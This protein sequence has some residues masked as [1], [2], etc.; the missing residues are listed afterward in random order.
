MKTHLVSY[1]TARF[2][3]S[4]KKLGRSALRHGIDV[5][6]A[7]DRSALE[8]T[9]FYQEYKA[10]LDLPRGG[11]YWL[12]KPFIIE[13][14]LRDVSPGD[15]VVYSDAGIDIIGDLSPLF[16]LCLEKG[17]ILLFGG[18]Y[19]D[20]GAPGPN[21]CAKWTKRDCFVLMQC[22]EA[23]YHEAQMLDAS[24]VVL[25]K[26]ARVQT[27]VHEWL[28][29]CG[30][31]RLLTDRPNTCGLPNF[32]GFIGHRHDQ[33]ILSLVA[34]REGLEIFRHPSQYGN[35]L[36]PEPYRQAGEWM[37]HPYGTKG[38]FH[39]SPYPTLLNHHRG[40]RPILHWCRKWL[41]RLGA[42]VW[43]FWFDRHGR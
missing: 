19:D 12:W 25:A 10:V 7:W 20:V 40:A 4:Q 39:N 15:I 29:C 24:F 16:T 3:R 22:D 27:L 36:K 1:A 28:R 35:H 33:S 42:R 13:D 14:I 18:H 9:V 31:D 5:V 38:I 32:P 21:L 26:T 11:G 17:G 34:V 8:E 2:L 6:R 30:D 41:T 43:P 23:R 37:R